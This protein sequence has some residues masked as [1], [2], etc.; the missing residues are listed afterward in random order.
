M[1]NVSPVYAR[2]V[3]R[4][5]LRLGIPAED[6]LAGTSLNRRELETGGDIAVGDF[7]AILE[8][9]R[10][11]SG[12]EQLGLV[13][14]RHTHVIALGPI[15]AAAAIAPTVREGLQVMENYTRLHIGHMRLELSSSLRGLSV[16]FQF[17]Q[18]TGVT[19]R[20]HTE[21]ALMLTQDYVETLVGRRVENA[22]Y[23]MTLPAPDY[24]SEYPRWLHSPVSFEDE[25]NS[26]ELPV[27]L[28]D[29][30][31]PYYHAGMWHQA[32]LELARRM[33]E[34]EG[35]EEYP[36]T[37]FVGALLRSSEPPLPDLGVAAARL[38]MSERTLN[39][40]LQQEGTSFRQIRGNI[41]GSWARQL[42][43]ETDHSVEA[44][45]AQLGYQDAA[46]FRRAF[47]NSE[48]C[49]PNEFRCGLPTKAVAIE[50]PR[51][52]Y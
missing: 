3:L 2:F 33:R 48:G 10:R 38:H 39:R 14:G 25:Y 21:T 12:N 45:S 24:A 52:K 42:L 4:E 19:E 28:L 22:R 9:G 35:K 36:Y 37:Q 32:T 31:S 16:R 47:R 41:L 8:N 17:L 1:E 26:A 40:R 43:T 20:F 46:N 13:I 23:C 27:E 11:L 44:I 29:L 51:P 15:G 34:L 5:I 6:L 50:E 18:D 7:L 49:S 30:P